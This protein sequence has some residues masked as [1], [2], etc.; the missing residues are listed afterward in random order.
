LLK[1][2]EIIEFTKEEIE[3]KFDEIINLKLSTKEEY[4]INLKD[5]NKKNIFTD[6]VLL[7]YK[8][9]RFKFKDKYLLLYSVL[10]YL[11]GDIIY[12]KKYNLLISNLVLV[13]Q[14]LFIYSDKD[15]Y[16]WN[17]EYND[18]NKDKLYGG[19]LYFHE[20]KEYKFFKYES[21]KCI[22][23][24]KLIESDII[25]N[26]SLIPKNK[27]YNKNNYGYIEYNKNYKSVQNG[28]VLKIKRQK[29]LTGNIFISSSSGEW[30]SS[31]GIKYLKQYYSD[32]WD[33]IND[34]D[35]EYLEEIDYQGKLKINKLIVSF[36]IENMM[37]QTE[38]FIKGDLMWLYKY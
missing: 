23:T 11:F 8:I 13:F 31:S 1:L 5:N 4:V 3:S 28:L 24:N 7:S 10:Q 22:I 30:T 38:N 16:L 34:K 18:S 33:N 21:N 2:P 14:S 32:L 17:K 9:D 20:R 26:L 19:F 6:V 25:T 36:L 27:I 35:K 37:R 12:D 15:K 29:D